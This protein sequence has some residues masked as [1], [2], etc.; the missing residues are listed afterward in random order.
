MD[1]ILISNITAHEF[2]QLIEFI[3]DAIVVSNEQGIISFINSSTE[4]LFGYTKNELL[5]QELEILMPRKFHTKHREHVKGYSENPIKRPMGKGLNLLG[6]KKDGKDFSVDIMLSPIVIEEK[7]YIVSV[8]RDISNIKEAEKSAITRL[9]QLED[10]VGTLTHDIKTPLVAAELNYKH[11]LSGSFGPLT[12]NQKQI[13]NLLRQSNNNALK[14]VK[15]LLSVIKYEIKSYKLL[16][17]N[18]SLSNLLLKA[19]LSVQPLLDEKNIKIKLPNV[20]FKLNC[21][22]FEL[23]RVLTNLL[24]N[25]IKYSQEQEVIEISAIKKEDGTVIIAISDNGSGINEEDMKNLFNRFWHSKKSNKDNQSTGLGLYLCRQIVEA[26]RGR[27]WAESTPGKGTKVSFSIPE[28][29]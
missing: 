10:V 6:Q 19:V 22:S 9:R 16:I 27:I 2:N 23:E 26:H 14:L 12:E 20:S 13:L 17:E 29:N 1:N 25:G 24:T 3:P 18:V 21:D 4:Q 11:F 28:M 15:N 8:I 7:K 5:G